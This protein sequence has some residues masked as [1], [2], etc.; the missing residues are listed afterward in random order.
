M[1]RKTLAKNIPQMYISNMP[2]N[3]GIET[4]MIWHD[5]RP[6]RPWRVFAVAKTE[7][8]SHLIEIRPISIA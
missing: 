4:K 6:T 7:S 1:Q 2:N 3:S 5:I 8:C